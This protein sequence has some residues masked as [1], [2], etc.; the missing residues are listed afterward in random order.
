MHGTY[1]KQIAIAIMA[2]SAF[3]L[4]TIPDPDPFI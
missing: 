2:A 3:R 4:M 1:A